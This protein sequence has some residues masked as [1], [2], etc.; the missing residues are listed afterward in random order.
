MNSDNSCLLIRLEIQKGSKKVDFQEESVNEGDKDSRSNSSRR[1]VNEMKK[2]SPQ[3]SSHASDAPLA[4]PTIKSSQEQSGV[5]SSPVNFKGK[6]TYSEVVVETFETDGLHE[7]SQETKESSR[8]NSEPLN[9]EKLSYYSGNPFVEKTEGILHFFKYNDESLSKESQSRMLCMLAVSS[10]ITAREIVAFIKPSIAS[11]EKMRIVRDST[12]NQYM[13][14][15]RFKTHHDCVIFY[16]EY[17]GQHFNSMEPYKC[18]LLFVDKIE[19]VEEYDMREQNEKLTELPTCAVCLER[20]DD[21][22]LSILCNHTFHADCLQ[23]WAD[24]TCPVCRYTQTPELVAD[25]RC[26]DCGQSTDLWICLICGNIGCGRYAEAHAYRHFEATSH[27]FCL[28]VGGERVWDYVGDNYVHRLIQTDD[29]QKMVEY[30]RNGASDFEKDGKLDSLKIEYTVLLT[31]QLEAQREFFESRIAEEQRNHSNFEKMAIAQMDDLEDQLKRAVTECNNLRDQLTQCQTSKASTDK[32]QQSTQSKLNKLQSDLEE[33]RSLNKALRD[34]HHKWVSK[35][36]DLEKE[37][38][39]S[40][41]E[42]AELKDQINDLLMHFE[43]QTKIQKQLE[44]NTIT[45]QEI[46]EG[47]LGVAGSTKESGSRRRGNRHK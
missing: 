17:N 45:T 20:M 9:I 43:A 14:I 38:Q 47:Q 29:S 21:G 32:K 22:V 16:E 12:P 3:A 36:V 39:G 19:T 31:S 40:S 4:P 11:I 8:S 1:V 10:E 33:E 37:K 41:K 46:E 5:R 34:D 42:I 23:K 25:Q 15:L 13:I 24:T 18:S 7:M 28:Q 2:R 35:I 6:R 26:S 44:D 30:Q 27:T